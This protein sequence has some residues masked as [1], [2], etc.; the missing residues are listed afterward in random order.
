MATA[1]TKTDSLTDSSGRLVH[2]TLTRE[3]LER[4]DSVGRGLDDEVGSQR[5]T[6][7]G[8]EEE[9]DWWVVEV[10]GVKGATKHVFR[11]RVRL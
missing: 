1:R 9:P 10:T 11:S 4:L 6:N 7:L 2:T 8:T 5:L 3:A